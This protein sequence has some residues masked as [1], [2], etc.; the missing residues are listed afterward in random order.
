MLALQEE[1]PVFSQ[2]T[3]VMADLIKRYGKQEGQL[4]E[5]A[6]SSSPENPKLPGDVS[7]HNLNV[8][9]V[10][11]SSF[12]CPHCQRVLMT[13]IAKGIP[14]RLI[15]TESTTPCGEAWVDSLMGSNIPPML[16]RLNGKVPVTPLSLVQRTSVNT[17]S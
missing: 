7:H 4:L 10:T 11:N 12:K 9:N 8:L 3:S 6:V 2:A 13:L 16:H 1:K 17:L 5:V 14:F 15:V